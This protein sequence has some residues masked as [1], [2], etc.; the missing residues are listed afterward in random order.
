[1]KQQP[2]DRKNPDPKLAEPSF[3]P[4]ALQGREDW[5][6]RYPQDGLPFMEGMGG[7]VG[8]G[9]KVGKR[10]LGLSGELNKFLLALV[11]YWQPPI[12]SEDPC[13]CSQDVRLSVGSPGYST[14]LWIPFI[15][16]SR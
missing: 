14:P 12:S 8:S 16:S 10:P 7:R 11:M 1:M 4:S 13:S 6:I 2:E 15:F 5:E 9:A 3:L